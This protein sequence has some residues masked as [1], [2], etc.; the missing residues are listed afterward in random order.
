MAAVTEPIKREVETDK[1]RV[2]ETPDVDLH[3]TDESESHVETE[4]IE[5]PT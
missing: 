5:E 2:F 1:S 4:K 3:T